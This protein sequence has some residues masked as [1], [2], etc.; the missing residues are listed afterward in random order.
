MRTAFTLFPAIVLAS[1][2]IGCAED[3]PCSGH[4]HD[5]ICLVCEQA[6]HDSFEAG[7]AVTGEAGTFTIEIV[8]SAPAPHVEGNNDLVI[9]VLDDS[10]QPVEGI[11]FELIQT[12]YPPGGHGSPIEPI[13]VD[14]G[15]GEYQLTLINY[16]HNGI[17]WLRFLLGDGARSDEVI[18]EF[19]ILDESTL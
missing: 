7:S 13:A 14:M 9:K 1:S 19:C 2:L 16:V 15:G 18:F 11:D 3:D 12:W 17:W 6:D 5:P 4:V 8:S 10:N